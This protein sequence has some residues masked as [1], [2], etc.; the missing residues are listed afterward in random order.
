MS[1]RSIL[2]LVLAVVAVAALVVLPAREWLLATLDWSS[3]NPLAAQLLFVATYVVAAVCLLPCLPLTLA[4]GAVFGVMAGTV[5]VAIGSTLGATAAFFVGR[6]FARRWVAHKVEAWP[7]FHA[8]DRAVEH[9]GLWVV[10]LT[11]LSPAF[12]FILVNYAFGLTRLR[13]APY[14]L[15][16][17][18]GMLP[19]TLTY[20]YA[21][22]VAASVTQALAGE[23]QVGATGWILLG[24][25]LVATVAVTALVTRTAQR[26]LDR[27]IEAEERELAG[28]GGRRDGA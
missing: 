1:R 8:L 11:R 12:P 7:R 28:A 25:G 16:S 20:V 14:I 10:L 5:L 24:L 9:H 27:E 2:L 6:T 15:G 23:A 22:S 4:A 19:L 21:G 18:V 17:L 3:R 13:P 26:F